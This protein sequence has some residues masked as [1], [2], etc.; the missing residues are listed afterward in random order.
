MIKA[1]KIV[2]SQLIPKTFYNILPKRPFQ[3]LQRPTAV[4]QNSE[5][6]WKRMAGKSFCAIW[7]T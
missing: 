6:K 1:T 3:G 4:C 7:S 2:I 5:E